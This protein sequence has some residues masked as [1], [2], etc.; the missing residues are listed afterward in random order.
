MTMDEMDKGIVILGLLMFGLAF[1]C[2]GVFL[3]LGAAYAF[4]AA[5]VGMLIAAHLVAVSDRI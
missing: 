2:G 3:L 5:G 1:A 4:L